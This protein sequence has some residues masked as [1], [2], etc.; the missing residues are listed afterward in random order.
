[1]LRAFRSAAA[2]CRDVA[3]AA[4]LTHR[5]L[6][7]RLVVLLTVTLGLDLTLGRLA[8]IVLSQAWRRACRRRCRALTSTSDR[9][10]AVQAHRNL[11]NQEDAGAGHDQDRAAGSRGTDTRNQPDHEDERSHND[12]GANRWQG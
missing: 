3:R 4:T 5:Y 6:R 12:Q 1:M 7:D 2:E 11:L 8:R 10:S 9:N